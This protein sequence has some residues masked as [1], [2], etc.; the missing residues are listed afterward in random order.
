MGRRSGCTRLS[1][2]TL[3]GRQGRRGGTY[4]RSALH[5]RAADFFEKACKPR[6]EWK[7]RPDL[8]AHLQRLHHLVCGRAY[9]IACKLL[10]EIDREH[11]ALWGYRSEIIEMRNS[12]VGHLQDRRLESINLGNMGASHIDSGEP[13][14]G[15]ECTER[16]LLIAREVGDRRSEGRWMGNIALAHFALGH[17][18]EAKALCEQALVIAEEIGDVLH[19]G[20]W[21]G[22]LGDIHL[23]LGAHQEAM[24]LYE[25]ALHIA[26]NVQDRRFERIWLTTL[27]DLAKQGDPEKAAKYYSRAASVAADIGERR[28]EIDALTKLGDCRGLLGDRKNQFDSY[29]RAVKIA[30]EMGFHD[31]ELQIAAGM[32]N[33]FRSFG[34]LE[35]AVERGRGA[36]A[37]GRGA[38]CSPPD[39]SNSS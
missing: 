15:L 3:T 10:N 2:S 21:S 19:I 25:Q 38:G 28:A 5:L 7:W 34:Q 22:R 18:P 23:K 1:R 24:Q 20:R 33:V 9:D 29:D 27:G 26:G 14:K 17:T 6:P 12:L 32:A 36:R 31:I 16:A 8:E 4:T 39:G 35:K 13:H 30:R 37:W 11:L